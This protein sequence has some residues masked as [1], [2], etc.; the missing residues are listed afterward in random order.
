M[1]FL[2]SLTLKPAKRVVKQFFLIVSVTLFSAQ[3][4]GTDDIGANALSKTMLLKQFKQQC[5]DSALSAN[6][7]VA[8][9]QIIKNTK[10]KNKLVNPLQLTLVRK[11]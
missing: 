9:Y 4:F 5:T 10:S 8:E 6:H 7:L 3:V 1:K 11:K 2:F